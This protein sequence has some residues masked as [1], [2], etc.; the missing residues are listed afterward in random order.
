MSDPEQWLAFTRDD[1]RIVQLAMRE[2]LFNQVCFHCQQCVE[3]SLKA[4]IVHQGLVPPRIHKLPDLLGQVH[5]APLAAMAT[6]IQLLDRFYT[7]TRYPG[8]TPDV[9]QSL[10]IQ[11]DA[12]EALEIAQRV[13]AYVTDLIAA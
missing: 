5:A 3:K 7:T 10:P 13:L 6:E 9:P 4:L 8:F 1:V 11:R 2:G 12:E